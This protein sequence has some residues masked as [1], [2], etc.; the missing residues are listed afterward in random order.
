M[1]I[2]RCGDL[3]CMEDELFDIFIFLTL[4][5][6]DIDECR[7][8]GGPSVCHHRCLNTHGSYTCQCRQGFELQEDGMTCGGKFWCCNV[9]SSTPKLAKHFSVEKDF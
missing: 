7:Q 1:Y 6:A 9:L 5:V 2:W 3:D 8:S 4:F